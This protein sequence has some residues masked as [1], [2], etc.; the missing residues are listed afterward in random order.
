MNQIKKIACRTYQTV[1]KLAIPFIKA[2]CW[3]R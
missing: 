1:F 3:S 2:E